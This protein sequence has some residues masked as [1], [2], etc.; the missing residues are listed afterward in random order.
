MR[1]E[2]RLGELNAHDQQQEGFLSLINSCFSEFRSYLSDT[3]KQA[4]YTIRSG[5][6]NLDGSIVGLVSSIIAFIS[7]F[8]VLYAQDHNGVAKYA[9]Y[10][11]ICAS[12][13]TLVSQVNAIFKDYITWDDGRAQSVIE[14]ASNALSEAVLSG[15]LPRSDEIIPNSC[16]IV[17]AIKIGITSIVA[18]I[19]AGIGFSGIQS[20]RDLHLSSQIV[21]DI[22]KS[23]ST[24]HSLFDYVLQDVLGFDT[25]KD[26]P[27]VKALER[28]VEQGTKLQ[29]KSPA[30]FVVHP[31]LLVCLNNFVR[32]VVEVTSKKMSGDMSR[33]Y[34]TTKQILLELYRHLL[35]KQDSV[36]AILATRPRQ[37]T[38]GLLLSGPPGHGK[39]EFGKYICR[40]VARALG[41]SERIY[42]LNKKQ[43]GFYEPYG[44]DAIG[45]YNEFM[46]MRAED[47]ILRDINLITS[48]DPMNFEAASLDGKSQPC[49]LKILFMTA[50]N[51]NPEIVRALSEGATSALWDRFYHISVEDPL[52]KGRHYPNPHRKPDFSHLKLQLVRHIT[53]TQ[54]EFS[55][56]DIAT[57]QQR[58]I[59]RVATSEMSYLQSLREDTSLEL[60]EVLSI[61][62][63]I[64]RE[65]IAVNNPYD[66]YALVTPN[67][68]GRE[69]FTIR[70]QG[71]ARTGK[72]TLANKIA[73]QLSPLFAYDV[74]LSYSI[75]EFQP[76]IDAPLIYL[77]DDW[78][79]LNPPD[80][81]KV[82]M[83]LTHPLSIFII[84]D[85]KGVKRIKSLGERLYSFIGYPHN[86]S[87]D[88]RSLDT[89]TGT[90]C[91]LGLQGLITS[92]DGIVST[93][94]DYNKTYNFDASYNIS[95]MYGKKR[96]AEAVVDIAFRDY[97]QF[98]GIPREVCEVSGPPPVFVEPDVS[99][100]AN[101]IQDLLSCLTSFRQMQKALFNQHS[102]VKLY[103]SESFTKGECGGQ[104]SS[105]AWMI[106]DKTPSTEN[107]RAIWSKMCIT[108]TR[109]FPR[110][111]LMV[112][113]LDQ[114]DTYYLYHGV[115]YSYSR[116]EHVAVRSEFKPDCALFYR[117]PTT[118]ISV[119]YQQLVAAIV[120][121]QF[122]GPLADCSLK[123]FQILS[124]DYMTEVM[125][126]PNTPIATIYNLERER[127]RVKYDPSSLLSAKRW[128]SNPLFCIGIGLLVVVGSYGILTTLGR[129]ISPLIWSS[130]QPNT[131]ETSD[132][133]QVKAVRSIKPAH[134]YRP[135]VRSNN[136]PAR[137]PD[138]ALRKLAVSNA[139]LREA[140]SQLALDQAHS[141]AKV[142][143]MLSQEDML[144]VPKS[145]LDVLHKQLNKAYAAL[146]SVYGSCYALHLSGG[147]FLTVG[148]LIHSVDDE[149]QLQ[150]ERVR[151]PARVYSIMRERD[152]AIVKCMD[153][154][155]LPPTTA[156]YFASRDELS[157]IIYAYFMRC[158]PDCQVLGGVSHYHSTT[159][160]PLLS[161]QNPY[162]KHEKELIVHVSLGLDK[163]LSFVKSGD[164]GFPL[165]GQCGN[166]LKIFGIHNAYNRSEKTY[167]SAFSYE[168]FKAFLES[169]TTT[170]MANEEV[171]DLLD[172]ALTSADHNGLLPLPYAEE[173]TR[174]HPKT[175]F[176][177]YR[178][179]I[180]IEGY[181]PGLHFKSRPKIG[182]KVL[183]LPDLEVPLSTLPA[184]FRMD[185]VEDTAEL[186]HD[187][188]GVPNP[189]FSQCVKY[190][191]RYEPSFDLK[192]FQHAVELVRQECVMKYGGCR[193]LR[194]HETVN[195]VSGGA[196]V[197][198]DM[199]TSAGPLMKYL[200]SIHTK[201]PLF[202]RA[203]TGSIVFR[204]TLPARTVREHYN[205]F[206]ES[207]LSRAVCPLILSKD[208]AKVELLPADKA[209]AG[210]VRLFN[211]VDLAVNL[212][213]RKFFGDF[214]NKVMLKHED[215]PIKMGM[216][217]YTNATNILRSFREI[218]GNIYSTD[219]SR[220]DKQLPA[221]LIYAF[222]YIVGECVV[223]SSRFAVPK[224]DVY[225]AI[226][227]TLTYVVHTCN[228][229]IYTVDRGNESGTF[230]TTLLNSVSVDI[231]TMYSLIRKWKEAIYTMP[232]L[233]EIH[234]SSRRVILGDDRSLKVTP[235]IGLTYYDLEQDSKLFCL[236]CT[237]SKTKSGIDFCSRM[238]LWDETNQMA[239]PALKT[240]SI[241]SQVRWYKSLTREQITSNLDGALF[242]AALH[243][244]P[245]IFNSVLSDAIYILNTYRID[246]TCLSF[247]SRDIIRERFILL[248]RSQLPFKT[249]RE[250]DDVTHEDPLQ[251]K[252]HIL[253][254][255]RISYNLGNYDEVLRL[256]P[257]FDLTKCINPND[258]LI[259]LT[260]VFRRL[261]IDPIPHLS[262]LEENGLFTGSLCLMGKFC[263]STA[264]RK[265]DCVRQL[266]QN[267]IHL[268]LGAITA[269]PTENSFK[270][271]D[272]LPNSSFEDLVDYVTP[273][274][275]ISSKIPSISK[276]K[277]YYN[278]GTVEY[279]PRI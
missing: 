217:P 195:G 241:Y 61:R 265:K 140:V 64:L 73:L 154:T 43:D 149:L 118:P 29:S 254:R 162:Y 269:A 215:S 34:N 219:F 253:D 9:L 134:V 236:T 259:T 52:C 194:M 143:N 233:S 262:V 117:T 224:R 185:F 135:P 55:D 132:E 244:N 67:A 74:Q 13:I 144:V 193:L 75:T 235:W 239:W 206:V 45:V 221:E 115:S 207:T 261:Q 229:I 148:H 97:R 146:H 100:T 130:P 176:D 47:P 23:A 99:I 166:T 80:E 170:P 84:T 214:S 17:D 10:T 151:H 35:S 174:L 87:W 240:S 197:P 212:W 31:D 63:Q 33:R 114:D 260:N 104:T 94:E 191:A 50:N 26:Y 53:N 54:I 88:C 190:D 278:N 7:S 128:S 110:S 271:L 127:A 208:C 273:Q 62:Q 141:D 124:Q 156:K 82:K 77:F 230:V 180:R 147:Y 183:D 101:S 1:E 274:E 93:V 38:I 108:F 222:C 266:Y 42:C 14:T 223:D 20:W 213:L 270:T 102:A 163:T 19:F 152:L 172:V 249:A 89:D 131:N 169:I 3:L 4:L 129:L 188:Y 279:V 72:T 211:E 199:S 142:A 125:K 250:M 182:H 275:K 28:L 107:L 210:K 263:T 227:R 121:K 32:D 138:V 189:L 98:L 220:F 158:G 267:W 2:L 51:H 145:D 257:Q 264:P 12:F 157:N 113:V 202:Q 258:P 245:S 232:S 228:G 231:L 171:C 123:E 136:V 247:H 175:F 165:V 85:N 44:G 184:A 167:F 209:K 234:N 133:E 30:D 18:V 15:G 91:R 24:F 225:D 204:D 95:D 70:L 205:R 164:C 168:D 8:V 137:A 251:S 178:D 79:G 216:N 5:F 173:L 186:A 46:A 96:S 161:E 112:K 139:N 187:V 120:Y 58:L 155:V 66:A 41:Y 177:N 22:K 201:A 111:A 198:L 83:N 27:Q 150:I 86:G 218:E 40:R 59:G 159:M 57:V 103:L 226:A 119:T 49:R 203:E 277:I 92:R 16:N 200:F 122:E 37:A 246:L 243:P 60:Q 65:L 109:T 276:L 6:S 242:E 68:Y 48:S 36:N 76:S 105:K 268:F 56:T 81:Y 238:M 256:I 181:S 248:A 252:L 11:S 179:V 21:E 78:V 160:F 272:I 196:L 39:S 106:S 25:S 71:N 153:K 126:S 255:L 69:F 192:I 237:E 116:E 90:L